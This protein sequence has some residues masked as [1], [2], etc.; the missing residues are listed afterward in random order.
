MTASSDGAYAA[1]DAAV[2][3]TTIGRSGL[4]RPRTIFVGRE[5]ELVQARQLLQCNGL[6]TLTG[7]GGCGKTRLAIALAARVVDEF[8]DGVQF[9]PLAAISDASLVPVS[10]AQSLGLQDSRGGP[11]FEHLSGYVGD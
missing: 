7:P 8:P 5:N 1:S 6:L 10:M 4:P 9:V 3:S 2:G 11:L